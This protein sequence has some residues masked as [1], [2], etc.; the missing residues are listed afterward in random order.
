MSVVQN[1]INQALKEHQAGHFAQAEVLYA[2]I[3]K[4]NPQNARA[5]FLM[6][7]LFCQQ[8]KLTEA[9]PFLVK[10]TELDPKMT[11]AENALAKT[12]LLLEKFELAE[13]FFLKVL[14]AKT[15]P[16]D[17]RQNA[18]H[19]WIRLGN[20]KK[21]AGD[22]SQAETYFRKVLAIE[23]SHA[24]AL[25]NLGVV[26]KDMDR[27]NESLECYQKILQVTPNTM[28]VLSN[29]A[30]TLREMGQYDESL[31]CLDQALSIQPQ[32]VEVHCNKAHLLLMMEDFEKGWGEYEWRLQ[33][34]G[35]QFFK[36]YVQRK[37]S[38]EELSGKKILV[39][40][41][42]G[43]GDEL[44]FAGVLSDVFDS[45]D[46]S[47]FECHPKLTTLFQRAFPKT[48]VSARDVTGLP[49]TLSQNQN[50]DYMIPLASLAQ[51]LPSPRERARPA[52]LKTDPD[53]TFFWKKRL[54]ELSAKPKIGVSWKSVAADAHNSIRS[55]SF[56]ELILW[57]D[58]LK[59][60]NFDFVNL[61]YG[62]TDADKT[63]I[64]NQFGVTLHD[65]SDL[66]LSH[67]LDAVASVIANLDL[68]ISINTAVVF[69]A[70]GL[71]KA[72]FVMVPFAFGKKAGQD[73]THPFFTNVQF[74][75]QSQPGDWQ[76][77]FTRVATKLK[78]LGSGS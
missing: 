64:K 24:T 28:E 48:K 7:T 6:G 31:K 60:P 10:A 40:G 58:I 12:Y 39:V 74:L 43:V 46:A 50:L 3:L 11:D 54:E 56:A 61:Q 27:L 62:N 16:A 78:H 9:L 59:N 18:I 36:N 67:D 76:G 41:E 15:V 13:K 57:Q 38:G 47:Y 32:N 75:A 1:Q 21:N 72:A 42:Q 53:K 26:L 45:C 29:Q 66:D 22:F 20:A 70:G 68:L 37:W 49:T 19:L 77:L 55:K 8:K 71:G 23:P 44:S 5:H 25:N 52:Y 35:S 69:L 63:Y 17:A 73:Q 4:K 34:Q 65:W 33:T 14:A 30:I 51:Y 2:M